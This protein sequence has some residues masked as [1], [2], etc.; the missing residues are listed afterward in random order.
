[1]LCHIL[2]AEKDYVREGLIFGIQRHI[3]PSTG[4]SGAKC[5]K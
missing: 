5:T 4:R 1:M 2:C 3:S